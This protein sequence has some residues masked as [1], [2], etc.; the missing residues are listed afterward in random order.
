MRA[1]TLSRE[2][3][4]FRGADA[5]QNDGRQ[6][7]PG[8]NR[9]ARTNPARSKTLSTHANTTIGNREIPRSPTGGDPQAATG[10]LRT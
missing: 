6:D 5:V 4:I 3:I 1:R 7:R 2:T 10:S 8:R 9:E